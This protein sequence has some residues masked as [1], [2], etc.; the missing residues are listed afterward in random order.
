MARGRTLDL[1]AVTLCLALV[2]VVHN[3]QDFTGTPYWL[4]EAWV[5]LSA[6]APL[7]DLPWV[8]ASTP[9]GWTF[10]VWLFPPDGQ[11]QRLVPLLFLAASVAAGYT[12]GR[13]MRWPSRT[14]AMLAG[15]LAAAAALL[16]PAQQARH[17]L[18]QYTADA[19]LAVALLA[20]LLWT[21]SDWSRR[22]GALLGG[23][24]VVGMLVSHPVALV[25]AAALGG[26]LAVALV[27]RAWARLRELVVCAVL[28]GAGMAVV[29]V[30]FDRPQRNG[31]LSAYWVDNFPSLG[32]L[33]GYLGHQLGVLAP[34]L[35]LPW[36]VFLGLA[37]IGVVTVARLGHPATAV[38]LVLIPTGAVFAGVARV[39]PL[40]DQRTSH[41]LFVVLAVTGAVGVAGIP[42]AIRWRGRQWVSGLVT[43][44][45]I[46]AF[47]LTNPGWLRHRTET[48]EDVRDE[49]A[50]VSA[51]WRPGDVVL[52][53]DSAA[54]AF[55]YYW[56][57]AQPIFVPSATQATGWYVRYP[58][59]D[60]VVV[61]GS[62]DRETV[63]E[64]LDLA[65]T[66]ALPGGRIWLVRSHQGADEMNY[67]QEVLAGYG[68]H[69]IATGPEALT[70]VTGSGAA[71][72]GPQVSPVREQRS[73]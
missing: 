6:K 25:G 51:H 52:V 73:N 22:R 14:L 19:C 54:Y 17:D 10:L 39:Y 67:W 4:D 28:T 66:L 50:Y 2:P 31:Q 58:P 57:G 38:T 59:G 71:P 44:A 24:I 9:I 60:R 32:E 55:A 34:L 7:G 26:L 64:S 63:Q 33:P 8:S 69:T 70:V 35:G 49:V 27:R 5:A 47:T 41:Y 3:V 29:Y 16:L 48:G 30:V 12:F 68:V 53:N 15:L 36:P 21:E 40:L 37:A 62:R 45:S 61:A 72:A 13:L 42:A 20:V 46:A 56:S 1:G 65:G 11:L 23:G 43:A 18:K